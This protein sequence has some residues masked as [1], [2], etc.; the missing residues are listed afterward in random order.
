[1][2]RTRESRASHTEAR[3]TFA[4]RLQWRRR[5]AVELYHLLDRWK[6]PDIATTY[7]IPPLREPESGSRP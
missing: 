5:V 4:Q 6:Y 1:M 3:P 7:A 2:D